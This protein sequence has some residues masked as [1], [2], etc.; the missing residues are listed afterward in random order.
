LTC[1]VSMQI[2]AREL[3]GSDTS[4]HVR[5]IQ[6]DAASHDSVQVGHHVCETRESGLTD[7]AR[8]ASR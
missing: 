4:E 7:G 8:L 6:A 5:G 3:T 1:G 2:S